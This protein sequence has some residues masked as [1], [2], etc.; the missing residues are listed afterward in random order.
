VKRKTLIFIVGP[1]GIGKTN[2]A[3]EIAEQLKTE[4]ISCDSRQ[5]YKEMRIGTVRPEEKQLLRVKH[6]FIASHSVHDYYSA[7]RYEIEV[8]ELLAVLFKVHDVVVMVGGSGLY[9]DAVTKGIDDL[10]DIDPEVRKNLLQRYN[11]EGIAGLRQELLK[12]DPEHCKNA[13][14]RNPKRV[15]KALEVF[16][17]TGKP[18]SEFLT[19]PSKIRDFNIVKIGL[20]RDR[21]E[22]YAIIDRRVDTMMQKGLLDEVKG[23]IPERHLNALNTVGYKELLDYIDNKISYENAVELIKRNTRRYA[24]RQ[25]TWFGRDK[26]IAW[27]HPEDS[28]G[29]VHFVFNRI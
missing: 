27:F 13:D 20:N 7:G 17:M 6:H 9:V 19:K 3:V 18:Y 8:L 29:I 23:L 28:K 5:I 21:N 10:P 26:E 4:I 16:Y 12:V 24:K 22:L 2:L 1:T 11:D 15:L 25:L 14:I